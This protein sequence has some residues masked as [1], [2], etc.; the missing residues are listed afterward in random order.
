[1]NFGVESHND[2]QDPRHYFPLDYDR[3]VAVGR[4][5][6]SVLDLSAR[7]GTHLETVI[8]PRM[9]ARRN[10]SSCKAIHGMQDES[11][12]AMHAT[13]GFLQA[14][15]SLAFHVLIFALGFVINR[16]EKL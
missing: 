3:R 12:R 2:I 10:S 9:A 14:K 15:Q 13:P 4:P 1:M 8:V 7:K 5:L 6:H 11:S 16:A